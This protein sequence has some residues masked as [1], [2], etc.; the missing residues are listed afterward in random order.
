MAAPLT[1]SQI[2]IVKATVPVL[3]EHGVTITTLFYK[4]LLEAHPELRN[5]FNEAN[6]VDGAQ[7]RALAAAVWAYAA[8]VD[9]LGKLSAAVARIAYKHASLNVQ[10]EHY[11]IVGK[12]LLGAVAEVLGAACTPDIVDAVSE[13]PRTPLSVFM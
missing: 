10:P 9:E 4:N 1:P 7:P 5:V 13:N 3:K 2:A 6:Q 12:F 8:Y 11:P